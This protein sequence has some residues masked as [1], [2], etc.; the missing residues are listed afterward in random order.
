[1]EVS[2]SDQTCLCGKQADA[3]K[4]QYYLSVG[5]SNAKKDLLCEMLLGSIGRHIDVLVHA[6]QGTISMVKL[7]EEQHDVAISGADGTVSPAS[8]SS[9]A[10]ANTTASQH[11]EDVIA[12]IAVSSAL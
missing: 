11:I 12:S 9:V 8:D 3:V 2:Y 10:N 5:V 1:V 4:T 7:G 6:E